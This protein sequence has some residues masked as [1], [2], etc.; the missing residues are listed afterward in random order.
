[1]SVQDKIKAIPM[2]TFNTATLAGAYLPINHLGLPHA[3]STITVMNESN[4]DLAVSYDGITQ[5]DILFNGDR[6]GYMPS[7]ILSQPTNNKCFWPKGTKIY[8]SSA[9]GV[10]NVYLTG[11][12]QS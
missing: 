6:L 9:A 3:C 2:V 12:Y 5:H 1:M 4:V 10:G 8:V 11:F 7:Q